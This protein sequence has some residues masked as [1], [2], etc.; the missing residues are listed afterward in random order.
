L[1]VLTFNSHQPYLH[2]LAESLPW[3]F[4][5]VTPRLPSG[6]IKTWDPR[7]RP[8]PSNARIYGS[9]QEAVHDD[10][11]DWIL[12]HNVQD[13]LDV[14]DI[15]LPKVFLVHGTLSGRILQDRS[16]I[17]R[18]LY[19]KNLRLLL[20]ASNSRVV[21]I[22]ELKR[23]DWG[24]PGE[25][26]RSAVDIRQY[27]GYRGNTRGILQVCNH[28][29][30]RGVMMGWNTYQT[31]CRDLPNLVLGENG[32]LPSSR[33]ADGWE[34]LKEQLR[35]F[36]V[37][38]YTPVYPYEDGF[39]LGLLEAMATG[40]PVAT[41]QHETSPIRDGLEGVVASNTEELRGKIMFLLDH[42][43]EASRMGNAARARVEQEFAVSAFRSAWQSF[44][45]R[46]EKGKSISS[47]TLLR[48]PRSEY[49]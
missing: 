46:L 10:Y 14:R 35:S 33:V 6:L 28:L 37:Y 5:I 47:G 21:Y 43:E 22:S 31:V 19:L 40:M 13:L 25:I 9:M 8:L 18:G 39:N 29:K 23:A 20:A 26:I 27:G 41:L 48:R 42:S 30:E 12:L 11:W 36:R 15:S 44:A 49:P 45:L 17:D 2:L 24:L 4:G 1:R 7:I 16:N 34:D 32:D 38:L 3:N